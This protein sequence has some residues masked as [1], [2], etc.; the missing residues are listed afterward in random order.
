MAGQKIA[1]FKKRLKN[2]LPSFT[3]LFQDR[4]KE[5]V[6]RHVADGP[7]LWQEQLLNWVGHSSRVAHQ[8]K[9]LLIIK[10]NTMITKMNHVSIF[11]LEP[12]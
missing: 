2:L 6:I 4:Q 5:W 10:T 1:I 12:E 11:V 9:A 8:L 3:V 7:L